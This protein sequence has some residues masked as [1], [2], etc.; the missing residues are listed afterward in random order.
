M[1]VDPSDKPNP[2]GGHRS[3]KNNRDW[4]PLVSLAERSILR[5]LALP[6]LAAG[7]LA[8]VTRS[9]SDSAFFFLIFA[10]DVL[11]AGATA[12]YSQAGEMSMSDRIRA[13]VRILIVL[14]AVIDRTMGP[15]ANHPAYISVIGIALAVGG[16]AMLQLAAAAFRRAE[17]PIFVTA[18]P[19]VL[20]RDG[21]FRYLRHPGYVGL[22]SVT[23]GAVL[24]LRSLWAAAIALVVYGIWLGIRIRREE[25]W[26]REIFGAEYEAWAARTRRFIPFVFGL[27][28]T[29]GVAR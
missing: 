9:W 1:N 19:T 5:Y 23:V 29:V 2:E 16:I 24:L 20:V 28:M 17:T 6:T 25:A 10:G 4:G 21:V 22:V 13:L 11:T 18:A 15:A 7:G 3:G 14:I 12:G 26:L 27:M 8:W